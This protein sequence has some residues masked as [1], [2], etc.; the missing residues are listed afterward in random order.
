VSGEVV[1]VE[2]SERDVFHDLDGCAAVRVA[3]TDECDALTIAVRPDGTST[4]SNAQPVLDSL[5][6][7]DRPL[8]RPI[9][10]TECGS[11]GIMTAPKTAAG[12]EIEAV[13]TLVARDRQ[14]IEACWAAA[15]RPLLPRRSAVRIE[16]APSGEVAR[17]HPD[18][19]DRSDEAFEAC[20]TQAVATWKFSPSS[21]PVCLQIPVGDP[22]PAASAPSSSGC[23]PTTVA[24]LDIGDLQDGSA[25]C[26]NT[27]VVVAPQTRWAEV[28]ATLLRLAG[29]VPTRLVVTSS[30]R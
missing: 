13:E 11:L 23:R 6:R 29:P 3:S 24:E 4:V 20:L 17:I 27:F 26:S 16:V 18:V 10:F 30:S 1:S 7:P 8:P 22:S 19:F 15:E 25:S 28:D 9:I 5:P 14:A 2:L 12:F 21:A